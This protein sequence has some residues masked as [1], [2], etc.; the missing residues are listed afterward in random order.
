M[1][2]EALQSFD[3]DRTKKLQRQSP[4]SIN[5]FNAMSRTF[6]SIILFLIISRVSRTICIP[7]FSRLTSEL[8][9]ESK[10]MSRVCAAS[11]SSSHS[12]SDKGDVGTVRASAQQA[13]CQ[14]CFDRME[15]AIRNHYQQLVQQTTDEG[16]SM[17][18]P[19]LELIKARD[20]LGKA[21]QKEV[22]ALRELCGM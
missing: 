10:T 19:R 22:M 14:A 3:K 8:T 6:I 9:C 7:T 13:Y 18:W 12:L 20:N 1:N 5:A 4:A 11:S 16:L 2:K 15:R 21:E 17:R